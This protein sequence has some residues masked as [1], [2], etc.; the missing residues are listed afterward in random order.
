ML[1]P[2][3]LLLLMA[4]P[5]FSQSWVSRGLED[6][7]WFIGFAAPFNRDV[8]F[9]CGG[10]SAQ[11]LPFT[12]STITEPQLTERNQIMLSV[13]SALITPFSEAVD[14]ITIVVDGTDFPLP[15]L[16][17]SAFGNAYETPVH[18]N[19]TLLARLQSGTTATLLRDGTRIADIPLTGSSNA[20]R[21]MTEACIAGWAA[22]PRAIPA[23]TP[24]LVQTEAER[25]CNGPATVNLT[26][27][28]IQDLD[29]DT[30]PDLLLDMGAVFCPQGEPWEQRGAGMCGA[31]HCSN[32][33]YLSQSPFDAPQ[34]I[35]AI[36]TRIVT[37]PAG[38]LRIHGGGGLAQC[39]SAGFDA[40]EYQ[41]DPS[42]GTLEYIGL[43]PYD[44]T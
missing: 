7:V 8:I 21:T 11:N 26:Y 41:F 22:L 14:G 13:N 18:I 19:D 16:H 31:S 33:V 24:E 40:C 38:Q 36:G 15:A 29:G 6:G 42:T 35:L 37:T 30:L 4:T 25:Y 5:A 34:E 39:N 12:A 1:R 2:L 9:Q 17:Y 3:A 10:R 43:V 32:F 20:I 23:W 27:A 28:P 44:P